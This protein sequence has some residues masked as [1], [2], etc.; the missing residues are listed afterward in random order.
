MT[1]ANA[2]IIGRRFQRILALEASSDGILLDRSFLRVRVEINLSQPLP[3]GFWLR[4][5]SALTK[6]LWISYKYEKL[7][8]FCYACG[9][10]GHDN[11]VCNYSPHNE[12]FNSGYGPG[13]RAA[14]ASRSRIPIEEIRHEV[15]EAEIRVNQ[16]LR[17]GPELETAENEAR[18]TNTLVGRVGFMNYQ[19]NR[20]I[21]GE[22]P[23]QSL[24][25][26]TVLR[27]TGVVSSQHQGTPLSTKIP[28]IPQG[29]FN[30]YPSEVSNLIQ[31]NRP[32]LGPF[33]RL[34]NLLSSPSSLFSPNP[35]PALST[36]SNSQYF[37]TEPVDNPLS[38]NSEPTLVP[39]ITISNPPCIVE[40][41]PAPSPTKDTQ[42][43]NLITLNPITT[44]NPTTTSTSPQ[45]GEALVSCFNKLVLKRK[46]SDDVLEEPC[47]SKI[48]RL[49]SPEP[50]LLSPNLVSVSQRKKRYVKRGGISSKVKKC[51]DVSDGSS[52]WDFGLCDV[53][54]QQSFERLE[55][56]LQMVDCV[57]MISSDEGRVAGPEQ[58]PP[59][60]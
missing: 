40:I 59:Q 26:A 24:G 58:P 8:D 36:N 48:T 39:S 53:P 45:S 52:V 7:P 55:V 27:E 11:R 21:L 15:D 37:V 38:P 2:E 60:C 44:S 19:H 47:K 25:A 6:D 9:R 34:P 23:P 54:V 42:T 3:K 17:R 56:D 33:S 16:L 51:L 10:I 14:N 31:N 49:C 35:N 43:P 18:G 32:V 12:T 4:K 13:M 29:I 22:R 5:K 46:A 1:R 50:N 28:L 30:S 41:S 20:P 57:S